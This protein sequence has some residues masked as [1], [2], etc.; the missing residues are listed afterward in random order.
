MTATRA[1]IEDLVLRIQSVFL[2]HPT[3]AL[4]ESAAARRFNIDDV[5]CAAVLGALVDA[6][7]LTERHGTYRRYF[8]PPAQRAA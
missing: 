6:R 4:T 1:H 7:V 3:L 5:T 2:D 8:P